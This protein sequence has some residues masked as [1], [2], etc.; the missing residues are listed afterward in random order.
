MLFTITFP[1]EED[2]DRNVLAFVID[3]TERRDSQ[4]ALLAAQAELA[5]AARVATLGE[6]TASIAHEVNQPLMAIV[7]AG[8]A[9][10]R[11]LR[12]DVPDLKE[13]ATAIGHIVAEGRRAAEIVTRIGAF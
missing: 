2:G 10:L 7:T 1:A 12:R 5:H 9:G 4:D 13:V 6:L 11:W 3:I 8:E